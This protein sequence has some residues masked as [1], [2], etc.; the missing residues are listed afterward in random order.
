MEKVK[1]LKNVISKEI[2]AIIGGALFI[3]M[4]SKIAVFMPFTPV[5]LT[6]QTLATLL[7]AAALGKKGA[8]SVIT[9]IALGLAGLPVINA[10]MFTA[11]Y[12]VGFVIAA[13]V[14]GWMFES[15]IVSNVPASFLAFCLGEAIILTCGSI[16]LS[17]FVENAFALGF[18]PFLLGGLFKVCLATYVTKLIKKW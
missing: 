15:K 6:M 4:L 12:I 3:A 7:V 14:I 10:G 16:W 11:G 13:Y 2:S 17:K 9:Y 1:I 8:L 18:Y 5:P